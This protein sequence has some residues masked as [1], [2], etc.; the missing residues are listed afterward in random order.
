MYNERTYAL[1]QLFVKR[2]C[3]YPSS[4]FEVELRSYYLTGLRPTEQGKLHSIVAYAKLLL[5]ESQVHYASNV[6][7][8]GR[9]AESSIWVGQKILSPGACLL[10]QRT[11]INL[12]KLL[13]P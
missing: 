1:S 2:A 7:A 12:E 10:L 6:G 5:E 9:G 13:A 11:L 3:E 8:S 4:G